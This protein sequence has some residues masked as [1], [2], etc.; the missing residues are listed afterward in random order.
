MDMSDRRLLLTVLF[1]TGCNVPPGF[2][3]HGDW[4]EPQ[5]A[6]FQTG[7]Y[8]LLGA[9]GE[10]FI[11]L[12]GDGMPAPTVEWWIAPTVAGAE[13]AGAPPVEV[14]EVG[15][16]RRDDLWVAHLEKLPLG[17]AISYRVKSVRGD[18]ATRAF[19]AGAPTGAK[20]RFAVYGDTR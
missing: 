17:P 13:G 4:Q 15:M 11:A 2:E 14:H 20:F 8:I 3:E 9:P 16:S 6:M 12:K 19:H 7:P 10:A 5:P 1:A 18:T